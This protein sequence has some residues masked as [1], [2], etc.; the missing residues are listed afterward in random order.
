MVKALET[1]SHTSSSLAELHFHGSRLG[2]S[3]GSCPLCGSS[4][5]EDEF[6]RHLHSIET[7]LQEA[8]VRLADAK[9]RLAAAEEAERSKNQSVLELR[10]AVGS[11]QAS[12][13]EINAFREEV[14]VEKA[15]LG[16]EASPNDWDTGRVAAWLELQ[17]RE[18]N[19]LE[20]SI[21][22]LESAQRLKTGET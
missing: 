1:E 6:N 15:N 3:D 18:L 10:A 11:V 21:V 13:R 14:K 4:I 7:G 22:S 20:A 8:A 12:L 17:R 19:E 9:S 16:I 2:L 5:S